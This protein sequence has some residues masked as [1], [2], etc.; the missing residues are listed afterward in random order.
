MKK[1]EN[2][3][4]SQQKA[5]PVTKKC[6]KIKNVDFKKDYSPVCRYV[7]VHLMLLLS[8]ENKHKQSTRNDKTHL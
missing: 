5:Y 3:A 7:A 6:F 1:D 8:V 2:E 4:T